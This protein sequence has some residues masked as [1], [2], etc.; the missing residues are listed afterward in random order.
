M[1]SV[2]AARR[3]PQCFGSGRNR[4]GGPCLACRGRGQVRGVWAA[5]VSGYTI[6]LGLGALAVLA[7]L[8]WIFVSA[9]SSG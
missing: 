2:P 5:M 4:E 7:V 8:V 9:V 3:C 1:S 6:L